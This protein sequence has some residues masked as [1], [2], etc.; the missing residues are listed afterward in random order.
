[1]GHSPSGVHPREKSELHPKLCMKMACSAGEEADAGQGSRDR[2]SRR[3]AALGTTANRSDDFKGPQVTWETRQ[4]ALKPHAY[5]LG[6]VRG[7]GDQ[8]TSHRSRRVLPHHPR[9]PA[10]VGQTWLTHLSVP[11]MQHKL[12][13]KSYAIFG[14][15][16]QSQT[17]C[18]RLMP[19]MRCYCRNA[20]TALQRRD[21][22][23]PVDTGRLRTAAR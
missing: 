6:C 20:T 16:P 5:Y 3:P 22:R 21:L 14:H 13:A 7:R 17:L 2:G 19:V 23:P 8:S 9:P 12:S 18:V 15:E 4:D 11:G 10:C 1:M